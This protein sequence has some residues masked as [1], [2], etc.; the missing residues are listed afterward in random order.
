MLYRPRVDSPAI[1]GLTF[2]AE[3]ERYHMEIKPMAGISP[4]HWPGASHQ[5]PFSLNVMLTSPISLGCCLS[6]RSNFHCPS[7]LGTCRTPDFDWVSS[8]TRNG[9]KTAQVVYPCGH[10]HFRD[11]I[12]NKAEKDKYCVRSLLSLQTEY[13]ATRFLTIKL[14]Q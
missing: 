13:F 1:C 9:V 10:P 14:S 8:D 6:K 4:Q 12:I 3:I 11:N 2:F 5:R 7:V